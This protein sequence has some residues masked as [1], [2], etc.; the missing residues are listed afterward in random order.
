MAVYRD[1]A[2]V[3]SAAPPAAPAV[4]VCR[5]CGVVAP[6]QGR[7]CAVCAGALAETR[8]EVPALPQESLWVAVR[9]AF[10]CN[11]CKFLAPLDALDADG[12]VDCACCGLHQR[13]DVEAWR[14]VL[15]FAHA[16][17]DLAGPSPEGRHPH[18][19]LWIGS[20][21]PHAHVGDTETFDRRGVVCSNEVSVDAAPGH[22]VCRACHVPLAMQIRGP[23]AVA[24]Q[25]PRCADRAEYTVA[26]AA[27]RLCGSLLGAVAHEH[28]TDRPRARAAPTKEGVIALACPAC[29]APL[30]VTGTGR[31]QTCSFCKASCIVPARNASQRG[32]DAPA[33]E[34]WWLLFQGASQK[35]RELEAPTEEDTSAVKAAINLLKPGGD[36]APVG[37]A[38]GVYSAPEVRGIYWPQVG[39]TVLLGSVAVAIGFG[40]FEALR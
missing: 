34:V 17:G 9:C 8:V 23:G 26:D 1:A 39:L 38:P 33:P 30:S 25:C 29:G 35:R 10:V 32:G 28:R 2:G 16:V 15:A 36:S 14:E 4:S 22:P 6:A 31:L 5:R 13:F 27:R 18:P 37:D 3:P 24:T 21:N 12:A 19:T 11:Q 20:E 7:T 40:I